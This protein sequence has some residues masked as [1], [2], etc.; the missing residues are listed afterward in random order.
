MRSA[1]RRRVTADASRLG[2]K[3]TERLVNYQHYRKDLSGK[4]SS[5]ETALADRKHRNGSLRN[6]TWRRLVREVQACNTSPY[7]APSPSH[8]QLDRLLRTYP[9]LPVTKLDQK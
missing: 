8:Q 5:R 2:R 1:G 3:A 7:A 6:N 4:A 9:T